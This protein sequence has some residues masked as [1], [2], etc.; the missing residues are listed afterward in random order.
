MA[1][2]ARFSGSIQWQFP[3]IKVLFGKQRAFGSSM[4]AKSLLF[5][6]RPSRY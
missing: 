5:L 1:I 2:S 6:A 4:L 3:A